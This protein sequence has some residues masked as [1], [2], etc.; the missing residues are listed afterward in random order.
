MKVQH[1]QNKTAHVHLLYKVQTCI[2][3][4]KEKDMLTY[5]YK[6]VHDKENY[7]YIYM[8]MYLV[9]RKLHENY[10]YTT[11]TC[12]IVTTIWISLHVLA[13]WQKAFD[14]VISYSVALPCIE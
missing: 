10:T 9:G 3:R 12:S 14:V 2:P 5:M 11:Y 13:F 7:M 1:A 8:Y 4:Y 6:H